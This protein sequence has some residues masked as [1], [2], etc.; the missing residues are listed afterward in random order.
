MTGCVI[1][2]LVANAIELGREEAKLPQNHLQVVS[3]TAEYGMADRLLVSAQATIASHVA[4]HRFDG[5]T[6]KPFHAFCTNPLPSARQCAWGS[7]GE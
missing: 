3:V 5:T 1:I 2:L 6:P 4:D 7:M